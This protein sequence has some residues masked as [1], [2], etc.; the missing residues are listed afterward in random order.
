MERELDRDTT[1][2]VKGI[3]AFLIMLHHISFN[4]VDL[5][6]LIKP[7]W[8]IAFPIVGL[9]FFYSGYGLCSGML[10]RKNYWKNFLQK[11]VARVVIPY[12]IV[13]G[14]FLV[15][16]IIRGGAISSFI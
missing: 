9:F 10:T 7:I 4:I 11:R 3:A 8:Y 16:E 13:A 6:I 12:M 14:S 1:T 5:P 2:C 15:L